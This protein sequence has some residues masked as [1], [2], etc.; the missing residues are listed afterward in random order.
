MAVAATCVPLY[1][2]KAEYAL[3]IAMCGV[4]FALMAAVPGPWR[5]R[6]F[7][8]ARAALTVAAA[9]AIWDLT[10]RG[11][12]AL[13]AASVLLAVQAIG[14]A[15]LSGRLS[16]GFPEASGSPGR[17]GAAGAGSE[18]LLRAL[19]PALPAAA[20]RPMPR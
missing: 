5:L 4:Y 15:L 6:N 11:S 20:G 13:L 10:G 12:D 8:A 18:V 17:R 3:I 1:L 7:Y 14:V 19:A 9:V 2:D 16:V